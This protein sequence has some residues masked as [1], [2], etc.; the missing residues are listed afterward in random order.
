MYKIATNRRDTVRMGL[1]I[2]IPNKAESRLP[3]QICLKSRYG[4]NGETQCGLVTLNYYTTIV[5][6][7]DATKVN[8]G[9]VLF[10]NGNKDL[11]YLQD[12]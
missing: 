2:A 1:F 5:Q 8:M 12:I 7:N 11:L 4:F 10:V 6:I 9:R 3:D